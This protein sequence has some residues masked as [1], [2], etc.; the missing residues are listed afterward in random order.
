MLYEIHMLKNYPPVN[1][2]RDDSGAPKSCLFGGTTRGRISSQCLK[3]SWRTSPLLAQAIGEEHLGTRTRKL[4]EL[5]AEKLT[6]M[7][8]APEYIQEI[9]P[10]L[11]GF[12]NKEGKE[13]KDGNYTA[14]IVF[15]APEDIQAVADAVK[16]KL[17]ACTTVKQVKALK[18]KD[19]QEAVR[20]AEVRPITLD[21]ALF[22]RMVTSNAFR[23]VE[24]SMQV[25]HGISTNKMNLESDYFTAMDDLLS[26][27]TMEE[28]GA[29]I[30]GDTDYNAACYYIYASLDTDILRENLKYTPDA[31]EL[32]QKAIPALIRTMALSNPSGKQNSF[33]GN[34]LPSAVLVECKEEKVPVSMVN[35]FVYP[36]KPEQSNDYDLVRGSIQKLA[37]QVDSIQAGYGLKV[38]HRLWFC[39]NTYTIQPQSETTVC[40][41]LPELL[42]QVAHTL[43]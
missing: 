36:V 16:E 20:G 41:S 35:A 9:L 2:N 21:M 24:A 10:K 33:A 43:Q 4:P 25:A 29:A 18:A 13:N 32:I 5:V 14:Q 37:E 27:E 11:S 17:D 34:I 40:A 19:L 26:G 8:V 1:L 39:Q 31:E 7:D 15:Y 38:E 6:E 42:E 30:I 22:G 3:R 12:G 28:M 23:D